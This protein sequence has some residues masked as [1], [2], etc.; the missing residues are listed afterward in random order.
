MLGALFPGDD[1]SAALA[2]ATDWGKTSLGEPA[3]WSLELCGAVRTVMPS[4]MPMLLWW[5]DDLVQ[6]YNDA[7][8]PLLGS[9]HP[10]AMGQPAAEC[11][12]EVWD[13]LDPKVTLVQQTGK[14]T[15]DQ[16]LLLF[17]E[18]H[19]Y[20]EETYCTISYSP[21]RSAD[22][23]VLGMFVA[24]TDVTAA[25]VERRRLDTIRDLAVLSSAEYTSPRAALTRVCDI[26]ASNRWAVPFAVVYLADPPGQLVAAAS[27]GVP[28]PTADLPDRVNLES[29]HPIAVVGRSMQPR[30]MTY[31][32]DGLHAVPGPLGPQPPTAAYLMPL[33]SDRD[34]DGLLV[35]G[36]NPYRHV[37]NLYTTF[38]T[39]VTRQLTALLADVRVTSKER[40][41]ATAL[42]E[43]DRGKSAFF[44]NVSHEFRTPITVALAG[45]SELRSSPLSA[46][47]LAHI[48]AVKRAVDRL[49]RL[50]DSL[51]DFAR[52]EAG[53]LT[54]VPEMVDI[55][56]VT[57]DVVSMFRSTVEAAG[58]DLTL[59]L[60][61]VRPVVTDREAWIKVV[62]NLLSNAYKFTERGSIEVT[63]RCAGD[64]LE[65]SVADTGR[66][67]ASDE[68]GR[69]FDRFHQ[70]PDQPARGLSGTGIGLALVKDLVQAQGGQVRLDSTPG[71]GTMVTVTLPVH[72]PSALDEPIPAD[73][74]TGTVEGLTAELAPPQVSDSS[75]P[76]LDRDA[77]HVLV[78]EDNSDLRGYLTRLLA[79][80][81]WD[82]TAVS[83]VTSALRAE[84]VPDIILSDIMLP[85]QS[86]LDLVRLIRTQTDWQFIPVVL[87]TARSGARE[88]AEGLEAGADDYVS[89]PFEAV[90]L[91]SRLRTHYELSRDRGQ[92]LTK[93]EDEAA[94]LKI[95]L[96]SNRQ[97]GMAV[98]IL[99]ASEKVTSEDA[100]DL[101][102]RQSTRTNRKLRDI[103]EEVTHT[104]QLPR[105]GSH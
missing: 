11:W 2:R 1:E 73:D 55:A 93:S 60:H 76:A 95:A 82:V 7:Y 63:V 37:D 61:D 94:N 3:G 56:Q 19:G 70:V 58:L 41:K 25:R 23:Q 42:A 89:K 39:L 8:R 38:V 74:V 44:A 104:G 83:D 75:A 40:A 13:D 71:Q 67:I 24:T 80:D 69:V 81:G 29:Q 48:D 49:N 62:A 4:G 28:V 57:G 66:G 52:A 64:V 14:A 77:P 88:V 59:R 97:I 30:L 31:R 5:G 78:V 45:L 36:L 90:E 17:V 68:I 54:P 10:E 84:R 53:M 6:I 102:R 26:L 27:Y 22:G 96:T 12:A 43:L 65:L 33:R 18:R 21:I 15:F 105:P 99:M 103:A 86:G 46:E 16:D 87:L 91:L 79:S 20:L 92:R 51:L 100:F 101:L 72:Q 98:G 9:K 34:L 35:L 47:Q 50:V 85:G 32:S